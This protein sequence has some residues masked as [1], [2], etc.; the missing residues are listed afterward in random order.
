MII[1]LQSSLHYCRPRVKRPSYMITK[2]YII[3][4]RNEERIYQRYDYLCLQ[5][6]KFSNSSKIDIVGLSKSYKE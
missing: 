2:G 5:H 4:Q 3:Y 1:Q 6:M